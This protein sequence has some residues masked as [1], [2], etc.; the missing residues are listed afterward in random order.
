MFEHK[1]IS[2]LAGTAALAIS[3]GIAGPA[4]ADLCTSTTSCVLALTQGNGGSGFGTGNFGTVDL[5]RVGTTVT[6]TVDLADNFRIIQTG[7][8]GVIRIRGHSGWW[9]HYRWLQLSSLLRLSKPRN[10]RPSLGRIWF[11]Q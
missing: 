11:F 6:I 10:K 4:S 2:V 5:E 1:V 9:P 7:F 3:V 8:P